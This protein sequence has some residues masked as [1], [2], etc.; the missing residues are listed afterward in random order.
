M[1]NLMIAPS[2]LSADFSQLGDEIRA[3]EKAG[4]EVIHIDVMD[5]HFVPNMTI[6]PLIVK[7]LRPIAD[8]TGVVLD[9]HLMIEKPELLIPS[10]AKAGADIITV[11]VET[12]PN[13][14]RTVQQI[15]ELGVKPSVTLNP[16]TPLSMLAEILPYIDMVLIFQV[17]S[18]ALCR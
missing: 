7:A 1:K 6:G 12:C 10:F 18:L 8:E 17:F 3:V 5:G 16:A 2:I 13:L 11:H 14:H 4:A 15:G 9:V